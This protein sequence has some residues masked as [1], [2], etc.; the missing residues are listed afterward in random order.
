MA[1]LVG[2]LLAIA[3]GVFARV[4][5]LDRDRAMYPLV[6]VVVASYYA[7]FALSASSTQAL[8][9]ELPGS[10]VF[11][12]AAAVG[13]RTTLWVAVL[14]L[15]GHGVFDFLHGAFIANPGVPPWWPP[16]CLSYD[17][18]AAAFLAWLLAS[19]RVRAGMRAPQ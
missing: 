1:V 12:V 9:L 6:T 4:L 18:T 7:L 10:A 16:F 13:F 5:G 8:L 3:V 2:V 15:A 14:A 11:V 19:G 17:V